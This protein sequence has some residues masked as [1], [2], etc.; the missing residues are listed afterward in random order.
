MIFILPRAMTM[1]GPGCGEWIA[2]GEVEADTAQRL[3]AFLNRLATAP[4]F[5]PF[6]GAWNDVDGHGR[7]LH[8]RNLTASVS[9]PFRSAW[10]ASVSRA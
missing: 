8:E 6:A 9:R 1:M 3:Q 4:G 10:G 5:L 2:A 7:L